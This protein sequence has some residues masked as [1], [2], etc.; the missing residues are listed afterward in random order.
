MSSLLCGPVPLHQGTPAVGLR[1]L[2]HVTR[3]RWGPGSYSC[4]KR[5]L[6]RIA[7]GGRTQMAKDEGEMVCR[8]KA[9]GR[10]WVF[11]RRQMSCSQD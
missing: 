4:N 10:G 8:A 5:I 6:G 2:G 3:A 11:G 9:Y 1:C 7:A